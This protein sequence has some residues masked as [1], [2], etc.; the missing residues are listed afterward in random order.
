MRKKKERN[1]WLSRHLEL[2]D[3]E[4]E[5][6]GAKSMLSRFCWLATRRIRVPPLCTSKHLLVYI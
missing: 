1:R 2:P 3:G 4:G 5:A 6:D